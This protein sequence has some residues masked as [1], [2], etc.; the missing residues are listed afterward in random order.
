MEFTAQAA[1]NG[2]LTG[3]ACSLSH[4]DVVS[5]LL[6]PQRIV[7]PEALDPRI[8]K[9]AAEL[10]RRGQAHII[11]L[12]QPEAVQVRRSAPALRFEQD[13]SFSSEGETEGVSVAAA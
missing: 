5:A 2:I 4:S 13:V 7:L 11:L 1:T 6:Q 9:A 10:L 3:T 12:G 8:L